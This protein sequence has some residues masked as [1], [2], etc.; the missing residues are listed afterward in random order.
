MTAFNEVL[1]AE[2]EA[3]QAINTA[4]NDAVATVAA[5]RTNHQSEIDSVSIKLQDLEKTELIS[6]QGHVAGLIEKIKSDVQEEVVALEK[7]FATHKD[8]LKSKI[9]K[10]F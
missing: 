7:R 2:Q 10:S 5:A 8:E 4:K 6:H 1:V 9:A 3:E